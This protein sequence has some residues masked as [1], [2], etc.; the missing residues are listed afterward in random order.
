MLNKILLLISLGVLSASQAFAY[1]F[2]LQGTASG[3]ANTSLILKSP[4]WFGEREIAIGE[5]GT[6]VY[7]GSHAHPAMFTLVYGEGYAMLKADMFIFSDITIDIEL[8]SDPDQGDK[9]FL[10]LPSHRSHG[11]KK[12]KD[13]LDNHYLNKPTGASSIRDID[14]FIKGQPYIGEDSLTKVYALAE[15]LNYIFVLRNDYGFSLEHAGPPVFDMNDFFD[16]PVNDNRFLGFP[17]YKNLMV[18]F[19]LNTITNTSFRTAQHI[20]MSDFSYS[21]SSLEA[22]KNKT[23]E[24]LYA[25]MTKLLLEQNRYARLSENDKGL[26]LDKLFEL[27]GRYPQNSALM[28]LQS[29]L[30]D[31][32]QSLELSPA[33][34]FYLY[35][36]TGD[37]V[38]LSELLSENKAIVIDVWGSWCKPCR[39]HNK[40]LIEVEARCRKEGR[41]VRFVSIANDNNRSDWH[42][43]IQDDGMS[44]TQLLA[45]R[46]FLERYRIRQYPTVLIIDRRGVVQK[47]AS[48]ISWED[49]IKVSP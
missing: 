4:A 5:D 12:A 37:S 7:H 9:V 11:F 35:S 30:D 22:S 18:N 13:F 8:V 33:P 46:E 23:P 28:K 44:W 41:D 6:F 36:V 20:D 45:N 3:L 40:K 42:Q 47:V 25:E 34:G 2:T 15:R 31:I 26:Y 17:G 27:T 29:E 19:N 10:K 48:S 1:H 49:I 39:L 14:E 24:V 43:A 38:G 16:L 21:V 32:V